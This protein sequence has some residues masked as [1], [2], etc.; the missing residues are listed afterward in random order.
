MTDP[1][2]VHVGATEVM[3]ARLFDGDDVPEWLPADDANGTLH[4]RR[5]GDNQVMIDLTV[6]ARG[7]Q[8]AV[9]VTVSGL[10]ILDE[11]LLERPQDEQQDFARCRMAD[12]LPFLRQAVYNASS[13]VWPVKPILLDVREE[14]MK[15][16][17]PTG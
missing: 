14:A 6:G 7:E 8:H 10:Y 9:C 15:V 1:H 13:Q 3:A 4:V 2:L 5:W 17:E 12:L 11:D 16:H